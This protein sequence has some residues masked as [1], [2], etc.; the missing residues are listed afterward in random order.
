MPKNQ[1]QTFPAHGDAPLIEAIDLFCGAGGLTCGL[2]QAGIRVL[3]GVDI[4]PACRYPYEAN[5]EAQFILEDARELT[6]EKLAKLFSPGSL[7]LLAGCAPC[8]PF[9]TLS[10]GRNIKGD[11]KWLLLEEFER[12][13]R[14]LV[15]DFVTME[16]VPKVKGYEPYQKFLKTLEELGYHVDAHSIRCADYG[17]PQERR[18]FVLVASRRGPISLPEPNPAEMNKTVMEA[19]GK[20]PRLEA[21]A[22][23]PRD[24]LHK[25]RSLNATNLRRIRASVPGGTWEDWP[26]DLRAPCHR[27]KTGASFRSV[28]ARMRWDRPSPTIT[29]QCYNFGT[30]RFGHPEQDRSITLREAAILQSFPAKYAFTHPEAPVYFLTVGRLI[31][32]AVPPKLGDLVGGVFMKQARS[33][34][35]SASIEQCA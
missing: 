24:R 22:A 12:L 13:V 18:R 27:R 29:T 35:A 9:S 8:Q 4:D 11:H 20:L 7:R 33:M 16:N 23:D 30:G 14:E 25:A 2:R 19:I 32:N 10:N 21:G 28:Y 34:M 15:P 26:E 31:G 5:N 3:A 6:G 1:K 17:I